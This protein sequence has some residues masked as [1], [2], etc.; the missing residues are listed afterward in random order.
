MSDT[1]TPHVH[2]IAGLAAFFVAIQ[3]GDLSREEFVEIADDG[4]DLGPFDML[5]PT[6]AGLFYDAAQPFVQRFDAEKFLRK[7]TAEEL[8][9][10]AAQAEDEGREKKAERLRKRAAKRAA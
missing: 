10:E 9:E 1:G 2:P 4:L 7:R 8:L 6:T 5:V 3:N